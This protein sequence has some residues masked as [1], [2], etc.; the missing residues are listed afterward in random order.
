MWITPTTL[1]KLPDC[2]WT[3]GDELSPHPTSGILFPLKYTS[4]IALLS[5]LPLGPS[6][7]TQRVSQTLLSLLSLTYE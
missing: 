7:V 1:L 6:P 3:M 4:P 5:S 2:I